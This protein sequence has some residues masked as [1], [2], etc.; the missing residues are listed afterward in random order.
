VYQ[1]KPI[2]AFA[3]GGQLNYYM[4]KS[5]SSVVSFRF[6][7]ATGDAD[8]SSAIEGNTS[9][10]ATQFSPVTPVTFGTVFSP[11]LT[12]ILFFELSGS[13]IPFEAI[14]IQTGAKVMTFIRP[15]TGPVLAQGINPDSDQL[16]LG[17][18]IDIFAVYRIMSDLGL[19]FN[20][21]FFIPAYDPSN[22]DGSVFTK[23]AG[24]LQFALEVALT[25]NM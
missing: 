2:S 14:P 13:L 10:E 21:G 3:F 9:G 12:N 20:G 25:L 16:Y 19:S 6:M 15:T 17:S 23:D 8:A 1:Y 24:V 11:G 5:S 7:G 18:E 22:P 4:P